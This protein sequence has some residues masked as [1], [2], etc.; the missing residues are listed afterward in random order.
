VDNLNELI[1]H[2]NI[3]STSL[4]ILN[5]L[6]NLKKLEIQFWCREHNFDIQF[7]SNLTNLVDWNTSG[8]EGSLESLFSTFNYFT[9]LEVL[10]LRN[11]SLSDDI[12]SMWIHLFQRN[13]L[14]SLDIGSDSYEISSQVMVV[15][16]SMTNLTS[17]HLRGISLPDF[18]ALIYLSDLICLSW[19][20]L[21][22][23]L[24]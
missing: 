8:Y 19:M 2:G 10:S 17:L 3:N 24:I 23:A 7:I 18:S 16:C 12:D 9:N 14:V 15:I 22:L 11:C 1:I 6:V 20:S 13:K 21:L 4:P 5:K